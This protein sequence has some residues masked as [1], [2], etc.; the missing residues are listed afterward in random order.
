MDTLCV[1][2]CSRSLHALGCAVLSC[3]PEK[4]GMA[5]DQGSDE[6]DEGARIPF[7]LRRHMGG[8]YDYS[9]HL[10]EIC[11]ACL[12]LCVLPSG[13]RYFVVRL[14]ELSACACMG[15]PVMVCLSRLMAQCTTA[16]SQ[17]AYVVCVCV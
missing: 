7:G 12:L 11:K 10:A 3:Q 4:L 14:H 13:L 5:V 6:E 1:Y 16:P 9:R 2:S 17:L 8:E 15:Q